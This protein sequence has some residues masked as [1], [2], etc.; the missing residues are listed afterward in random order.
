MEALAR[1]DQLTGLPNRRSWDEEGRREL[2][3][4]ERNGHALALVM[5]DLDNF[6]R[7]NDEHGHQAG[8]ALLR[9]A[10]AAWRLTIRITD[11]IARYGGEEFAILL[12]D[13]PPEEEVGV[14]DRLR[15]ATPHQVTCSAGI[16]HWD[17]SESF[18][19]LVA[20]ADTAL[21]EAKR[22]GRNCVVTSR[23]DLT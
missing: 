6:K 21:Y 7:F 15:V 4:A 10:A 17:R 16:A 18:E 3:R 5:L 13:C 12:P 9:D 8:D 20:R 1:T 19:R 2:S 22:A 11:F 14:L 23:S